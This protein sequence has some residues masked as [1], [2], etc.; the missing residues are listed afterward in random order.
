MTAS[1]IPIHGSK[2][3]DFWIFSDKLSGF[4][5]KIIESGRRRVIPAVALH[6]VC[7]ESSECA[8]TGAHNKKG[9]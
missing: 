3:D 2:S 8:L 7:G 5:S 9:G 6:V 1:C 4:D